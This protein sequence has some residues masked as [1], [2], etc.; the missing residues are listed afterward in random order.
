MLDGHELDVIK[1]PESKNCSVFTVGQLPLHP[2]TGQIGASLV[3]FAVKNN[4]YTLEVSVKTLS[5]KLQPS[6][7]TMLPGNVQWMRLLPS[8]KVLCGY[9]SG[10]A[11]M[12]LND[13]LMTPESWYFG[14]F[15]YWSLILRSQQHTS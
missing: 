2:V 4:V 11:T 9:P 12:N 6:K 14:A 15:F 7:L 3:C 5:G 10:F 1:I 8:G 13:K